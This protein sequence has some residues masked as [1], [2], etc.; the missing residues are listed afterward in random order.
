[1]K[2]ITNLTEKFSD[3][4][5][6]IAVIMSDKKVGL[7]KTVTTFKRATTAQLKVIAKQ[8]KLFPRNK[9]ACK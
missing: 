5:T 1:L 6:Q 2:K 7:N 3:I 9:I 4:V 8:T